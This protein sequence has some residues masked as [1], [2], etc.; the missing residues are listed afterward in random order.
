MVADESRD[1]RLHRVR[2]RLATGYWLPITLAAQGFVAARQALAPSGN[3]GVKGSAARF[4]GLYHD[5]ALMLVDDL[6]GCR[7]PQ[8]RSALPL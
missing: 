6:L 1:P 4:E 7:Q 2:P 3:T 5:I 8:A